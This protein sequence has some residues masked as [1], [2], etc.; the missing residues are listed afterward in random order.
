MRRAREPPQRRVEAVETI[1]AY[2]EQSLSASRNSRAL[3]SLRFSV[4][5]LSLCIDK[6]LL[7][8]A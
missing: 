3:S 1:E 7:Q 8:S 5:P 6:A 4:P 2:L